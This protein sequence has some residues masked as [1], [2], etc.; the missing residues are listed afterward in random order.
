MCQNQPT[1]L[2]HLTT[3]LDL[4]AAIQKLPKNFKKRGLMLN[5][6]QVTS[7]ENH[8]HPADRFAKKRPSNGGFR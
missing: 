2:A 4:K 7:E 1:G 6:F 3:A 8:F 5:H